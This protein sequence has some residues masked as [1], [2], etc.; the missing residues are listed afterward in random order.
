MSLSN[1]TWTTIDKKLWEFLPM[2]SF[3][4]SML[5]CFSKEMPTYGPILAIDEQLLERHDLIAVC[6]LVK[7]CMWL[8]TKCLPAEPL[9]RQ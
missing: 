2:G 3:Q 1:Q 4:F 5:Y 9:G 8:L 7:I 6:R